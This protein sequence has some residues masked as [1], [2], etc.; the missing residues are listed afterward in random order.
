MKAF[1]EEGRP[2]SAAQYMRS[3]PDSLGPGVRTAALGHKVRMH[4]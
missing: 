3:G 4:L 1:G 2:Q